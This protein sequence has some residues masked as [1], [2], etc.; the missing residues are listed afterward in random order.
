M[1]HTAKNVVR[2]PSIYRSCPFALIPVARAK[3]A[4]W[5]GEMKRILL[6]SIAG[7]A[8]VMNIAR[9]NAADLGLRPMY[10]APRGDAPDFVEVGEA[11]IAVDYA[12][13]R[14]RRVQLV[15]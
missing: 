14:Q 6:T 13:R 4:Q 11:G 1:Q 7:A 2:N 5:G 8:A 10:A 15:G 9:A 12:M 3:P